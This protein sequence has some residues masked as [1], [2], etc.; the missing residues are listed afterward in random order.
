[1]IR[2]PIRGSR[3]ALA[4][5]GG[6]WRIWLA[7]YALVALVWP[8]LGPLPWLA[9]SALEHSYAASEDRHQ[10]SAA[11]AS[12]HHHHHDGA[13]DVPG[14]PTHPLDHDCF[15]CQVLKHLSRCVLVQLGVPDVPLPAGAPVRPCAESESQHAVRL[16]A[17]PPAR[18]PP[19]TRA[20]QS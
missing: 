16:A 12:G 15:Q 14:S 7:C 18:G 20:Q 8:S 2:Q 4:V 1:M 11:L 9:E 6:R 5:R 13:A 17:L 19:L 3:S 10:E